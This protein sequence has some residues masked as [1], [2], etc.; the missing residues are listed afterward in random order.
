MHRFLSFIVAGAIALGVSAAPA[1]AGSDGCSARL[2]GRERPG[3]GRRRPC[4]PASAGV[5]GGRRAPDAHVRASHRPTAPRG[6]V[7][8]GEGGAAEDGPGGVVFAIAGA[9]LVILA[10]GG[11]LAA[12]RPRVEVVSRRLGL[13]LGLAA[14]L[15]GVA[16][17]ATVVGAV[18]H[19]DGVPRHATTRSRLRSETATSRRGR[20]ARRRAAARRERAAIPV[21]VEIPSIGVRAPV[22]RLGLNPDRSLEV[23]T[24]FGDTGWWSGG[25]RPGERGPAVIVGHVDSKTGPAIF[26]RLRELRR[27]DKIVVV[28][29]DGSRV[30]FT[31]E[32]SEQYPKDDFPT[33]R[34]YGAHG[35]SDAPPHHLRRRLRQLHR[36]LRRQHGRVRA[37]NHRRNRMTTQALLGQ[38]VVLIGGSAGI[39]LETARLARRRRRGR[40]RRPRSQRL[41][42]AAPDVGARSTAAFDADDPAALERFFGGLPG[43]VDHVLVTAGGPHYGPMLEMDADQVRHALGGHVVVGL[44][45][46]RHARGKMRPG[47]TLLLM[48]GT[49][50]R[51]ICRELGIVSAATAALPPF[52]AALALELARSAST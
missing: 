19:D 11:R 28:G 10:A 46:A 26:Y 17:L 13:L 44:E 9:A 37:L 32:G 51:K 21:R 42:R 15:L 43:Q 33:A 5:P 41:E 31:V 24:D 39:G 2:P 6:A 47:G 3:G 23:P 1:L 18:S 36:P 40:P 49:G 12:R 14:L 16:L 35:R 30:R 27:G 34:V 48:G 20:R 25:A 50:G 22:I 4:R 7:A 8:A 45:V 29:R 52:V 38:T